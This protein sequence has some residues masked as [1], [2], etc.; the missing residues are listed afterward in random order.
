MFVTLLTVNG[1]HDGRIRVRVS[2]KI[3]EV[4]FLVYCQQSKRRE[5]TE[6][7]FPVGIVSALARRCL[8]EYD[9]SLYQLVTWF[10]LLVSVVLP[11][12][13]VVRLLRASWRAVEQGT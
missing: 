5:R 11:E 6:E 3:G 1:D 9:M 13:A 8:E 12:G 7:K 10:G 4:C 2:G